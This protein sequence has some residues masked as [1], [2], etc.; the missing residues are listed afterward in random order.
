[1][2]SLRRALAGLGLSLAFCGGAQA[3]DVKALRVPR[4][5]EVWFVSDRTL[6]MI[7]MTASI[8]AGSA[9]DPAD[10]SGL[11]AFA[12]D[13]LDEGSGKMDASAFQTALDNRAIR[14]SI[15]PERDYLV[16]SLVTL[17]ENARE[18]FQ[19]LGQALAKPRFD[20]DAIQRVRAQILSSQA[21]EEGDP[22]TVSSKA[23]YRAISTIT[24]THM[25]SMAIRR[26]FP[27]SPRPT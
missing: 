5:E 17:S 2:G 20:P 6:P 26:L 8:P 7:A 10:K 27:R 18:A 4:G 14:L 22:P 9:Y 1:M 3:V 21:Q 25:P 23:L 15:T 13:L 19:L 11:A 12:A 16:I 24:P